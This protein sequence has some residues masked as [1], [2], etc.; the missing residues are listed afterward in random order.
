M[1]MASRTGLL[2]PRRGDTIS[3]P[4]RVQKMTP[5]RQTGE[6]PDPLLAPFL[7]APPESAAE[8]DALRILIDQLTPVIEGVARG[9]ASAAVAA[10]EREELFS[11]AI[12]QLIKK[13]QE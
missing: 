11:E 12:L 7:N 2:A 13:L 5:E 6:M 10:T 1:K 9:K 8:R 4:D 3:T